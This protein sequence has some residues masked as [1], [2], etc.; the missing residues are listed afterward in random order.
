MAKYFSEIVFRIKLIGDLK[1]FWYFPL[2]SN[3]GTCWI[4]RKIPTSRS[5]CRVV[6]EVVGDSSCA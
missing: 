4:Q 5:C 2:E 1:V 3:W 6:K